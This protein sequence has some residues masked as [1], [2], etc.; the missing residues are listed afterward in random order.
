MSPNILKFFGMPP[1]DST[2]LEPR[3]MNSSS[4][5]GVFSV[6]EI[7]SLVKIQLESKF[8]KVSVAGEISNLTRQSS[9][10][11]YFTLK[12]RYAAISCV[13]FR[14]YARQVKCELEHGKKVV[15]SG[16]IR[17]YEPRGSYQINVV[18]VIPAG[19][20]NLHLEFERLKE[21]FRR[22]GYF[23]SEQKMKLPAIPKRIGLVTSPTG[24]VIQDLQNVIN[25][26]CSL[27]L[28]LVLIP[29]KVQGEGAW[30]SIS[31]AIRTF[32]EQES[33]DVIILARGGGSLEDLWAFNEPGVVEEIFRSKIPVISAVGHETDFTL[34]DFVADVRAATPSVAGELCV[35]DAKALRDGLGQKWKRIFMRLEDQLNL[36][37]K[38]IGVFSTRNL[39]RLLT[40]H[41]E[42]RSQDL[43]WMMMNLSTISSR[44]IELKRRNIL[45]HKDGM[46]SLKAQFRRLLEM[47]RERLLTRNPQR[48]LRL[49]ED[50]ILQYQSR[51]SQ[52]NAHGFQA[53][54]DRL[55]ILMGSLELLKERLLQ[56][57]PRK[58]LES[59]YAIVHKNG[60]P[61]MDSE[62]IDVGDRLEVEFRSGSVDVLVEGKGD[63]RRKN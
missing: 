63:E 3:K 56:S 5:E 43:D 20:G 8:P 52:A 49:L 44:L 18:R 37:R 61:V 57:D 14:S 28:E 1:Q 40:L 45:P 6:S 19:L 30:E 59:G 26:R 32:N 24:A 60:T 9:G 54:E 29:V 39:N 25:R 4:Q 12:D 62:G 7:T 11:V 23:E 21:E 38:E 46:G 42:R 33:A 16:S 58:I 53:M 34:S 17:V 47:K 55:K 31:A 10:H 48:H 22:K 36:F 50:Q 27:G 51:V 15:V 35:P 2:Y 13:M 41:F